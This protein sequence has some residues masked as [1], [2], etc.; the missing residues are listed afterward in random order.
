VLRLSSFPNDQTL[1]NFDFA[2]QPA[3]ECSCIETLATCAWVRGAETVLIHGLPG[4]GKVPCTNSAFYNRLEP[5]FERYSMKLASNT[6]DSDRR[7]RPSRAS[8]Q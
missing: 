1:A 6:G 4:V 2:F 3:I 8:G 5:I 7:M